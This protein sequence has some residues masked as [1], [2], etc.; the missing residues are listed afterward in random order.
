MAVHGTDAYAAAV[1]AALAM[2]RQAAGR[3]EAAPHVELLRAP[4]LSIVLFRRTG[5]EPTQYHRWSEKLLVDQIGFVTP[6]VW[7]GE[8]VARFAFLHPDTTVEI[9]DEI[10]ATMA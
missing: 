8:T 7:E 2:A 5:W 4:D 3:I 6:T 10:L 9:V 1:E